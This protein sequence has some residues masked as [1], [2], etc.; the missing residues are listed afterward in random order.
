VVRLDEEDEE[1][2][3]GESLKPQ[4][5]G[6]YVKTRL[7]FFCLYA[8]SPVRCHQAASLFILR[9]PVHRDLSSAALQ[10]LT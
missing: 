7:L 3:G 8:L 1:D 4:P 5:A 2:E 9:E 10:P 6:S